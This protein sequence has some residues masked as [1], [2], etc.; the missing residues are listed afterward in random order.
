MGQYR[1]R[2]RP[3]WFYRFVLDSV[4]HKKEGFRTKGQAKG[5]EDKKR[6]ELQSPNQHPSIEPY[7]LSRLV[8]DYLGTY[9]SDHH[10]KN[11]YRQKKFV[12]KSFI[13]F[14]GEDQQA[15]AVAPQ[16]IATYLKARKD[17]NNLYNLKA[18]TKEQESFIL[19]FDYLIQRPGTDGAKCANRDLRDLKAM[20][21]WGVRQTLVRYN[22]CVTIEHY[23]ENELPRYIPPV[24]D[25]NRV[26]LAAVDFELDLLTTIYHT[27]GRLA[28]ILRLSWEDVNFEQR[29]VTLQT[30]KRKGGRFQSDFVPM[31]ETLHS[32]LIT[33]WQ[34]RDKSSPYVFPAPSGGICTK[35]MPVIRE[36]MRRL[37]DAAGVKPFGFHAIRHHV[38]MIIADSGKATLRQIQRMLRHQRPTTTD[39]YLKGL[40]PEMEIVANILDQADA[41]KPKNVT[42]YNVFC[43]DPAKSNEA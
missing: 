21:H 25:V 7:T 9:S 32:C 39:T 31:S 12:Y 15:E 19:A 23:P 28:E 37:C 17:A 26:L 6:L 30:R 36:M 29:R 8:V 16:Q 41:Q 38:A 4:I 40:D 1:L 34:E 11:T 20:Y 35:D 27:A 3:G 10:Q 42:D 2:G 24:E 43:N 33:R 13:Q 14:I 22:P 18:R 5:A